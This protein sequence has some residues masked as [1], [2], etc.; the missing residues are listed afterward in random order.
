MQLALDKNTNDLILK[1]GGGFERVTDGRYTIQLVKNKLLTSLGEWLLDP[2]LGLFSLDDFVKHPDIFDLE[3]RVRRLVLSTPNV[4]AVDEL[5]INFVDRK[6]DITFKAR[7]TFGVID[8]T[9]P[10]SI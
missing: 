6:L 8:L 7:T 4:L 9:I 2:R 5:S 1:Q 3:L 10:W